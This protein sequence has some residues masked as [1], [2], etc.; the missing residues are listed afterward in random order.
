MLRSR[1]LFFYPI[2]FAAGVLLAGFATAG[3]QR[4]Y[5]ESAVASKDGALARAA[6]TPSALTPALE[7]VM[8]GKYKSTEPG[9]T[10]IVTR[11]GQTIFRRAYGLANVETNT[12][13]KPDDVLR[14]GSITKQ[15]TAVGILILADEGKLAL[16]D[17]IDKHMPDYPAVGKRITIE[18][19]LTHTSGIPNYTD[20]VSF[21]DSMNKRLTTPALVATFASVALAFE[22]GSRRAYSN[23][24]Y[25]VLGAIIEKIAGMDYATFM[26]DRIF[27]PLGM[28]DTA[29]EGAERSGKKRVEGYARR[30]GAIIVDRPIDMSL[31]HA[32]GALISTVDDLALW[33][34]A[35]TAGK[36]LKPA[37]WKAAFTPYTLSTGVKTTY[38]YGW[39]IGTLQGRPNISHGGGIP[40]FASNALRLPSDGVYVAIISN[41]MAG[42]G[43]NNTLSAQLAAVAI[44]KP[45]LEY[46]E[47]KLNYAALDRHIGVYKSHTEIDDTTNRTIIREGN[48]LFVE[49]AGRRR[50]ALAAASATTFF[51]PN[52]VTTYVFESDASGNTTRVAITQDTGT[53]RFERISKS[54]PSPPPA[55]KLSGANL[56]RY[57]GRYELSPGF[58]VAITR[59]SDRLMAQATGQSA[60]E[61]FPQ[62]EDRFVARVADITLVFIK[63]GKGA[64]TQMNLTQNGRE[65]PAKRLSPTA[66]AARTAI[67]IGGAAIEAIIGEY[68]LAPGFV[69]TVSR[70]GARLF[71]QATNQEKIELFAESETAFFLK[72]VDAQLRFDKNTSGK[73]TQLVLFQAGR[74]MPGRK[75]K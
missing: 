24:G 11:N 14:L 2:G 63:D 35:I 58:I 28:K 55:T 8:E 9:A 27:I 41:T 3:A 32:S 46:K 75:I 7:A 72:V 65:N 26:A 15:F 33:D 4:V 56:D 50:L 71:S 57:V 67:A 61:V 44:G 43:L 31:P 25:V 20:M 68:E 10:V 48:Q 45:F 51:V 1:S 6:L 47:V 52:S 53:R 69:I 23:S 37:T 54:L 74:E 30:D 60:F 5:A 66:P 64:V 73:V 38:G 49:R 40:G 17:T 34:A 12:A 39:E 42:D 62:A 13:L 36:L 70:D 29:Y 21:R 18:H 59:D 16:S 19:L 22:P